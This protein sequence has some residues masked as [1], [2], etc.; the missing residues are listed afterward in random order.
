MQHDKP[1]L[2]GMSLFVGERNPRT[3]GSRTEYEIPDED[4]E[5]V[6]DALIELITL[7]R[8]GDITP[9]QFGERKKELAQRYGTRV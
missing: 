8:N 4:A 2:H 7:K 5:D 1:P 9:E 3:E 6:Y